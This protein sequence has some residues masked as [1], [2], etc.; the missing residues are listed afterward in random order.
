MTPSG[1]IL[2]F[3]N[4]KAQREVEDLPFDL[5]N[6]F[7]RLALA[8]EMSGLAVLRAPNVKPMGDG[9]WELRFSGKSGIARSIYVTASGKRVVVL[10]SFVKKTQKT[11][12]T[13]MMIAQD[14]KKLVI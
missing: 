3:V 9:L 14:R 1:W 2:T 12:M 8:I 13:A 11:P 6:A 7:Q 5:R 4:A 10:H